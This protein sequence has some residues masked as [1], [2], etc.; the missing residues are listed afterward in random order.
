MKHFSFLLGAGF[1]KPAGYPLA[2]EINNRFNN[3]THNDFF[4]H[5]SQVAHFVSEDYEQRWQIEEY[6]YMFVEEFLKFYFELTSNNFHYEDFV[7]FYM[8]LY[9]RKDLSEN[10]Q[11]FFST[12]CDRY[13]Y[14]LEHNQLIYNFDKT[15]SQ[16]VA[17][18]IST[19]YPE[20]PSILGP[21]YN[22]NDHA[23]FLY[24]LE[25]LGNLFNVHIHS[26]N[27]DLLFEKYFRTSV[28]SGNYSDGFDDA[29]SPYFAQVPNYY[30]GEDSKR[31]SYTRKIRLR[32]Y[33]GKFD[34]IFNYYK[35]HGSVD[36]YIAS[37]RNGKFDLIKSE[38]GIIKASVTKEISTLYG[39]YKN[40]VV[41]LDV[42][43]EILSGTTEKLR[44]YSDSIYFK[45]IH[46]KFINNLKNSK[47]LLVI[48]Y[49]F[50]DSGI[51]NYLQKYFL[52]ND[53][54]LMVVIDVT[55]PQS[56]ILSLNNVKFIKKSVI[57]LDV[58]E[59][60]TYFNI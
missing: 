35:L 48:G 34:K 45:D 59:I 37:I 36:N 2:S 47:K 3:L 51:N 41:I 30:C 52:S 9:R 60:K 1:S 31:K 44:R 16:L 32:R 54:K 11:E 57:D 25:F 33:K 55:K 20:S 38:Y 40:E 8:D 26:L 28:L 10:E 5:T 29:Y 12:F 39:E 18:I 42:K 50:K 4:I 58:E 46:N 15:F 56:D 13:N 24:L 19:K 22:K 14:P 6:Q 27:H 7:D 49:G 23:E 21:I 43:S 53:K 17:A